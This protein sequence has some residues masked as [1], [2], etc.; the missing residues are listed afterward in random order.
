MMNIDRVISILAIII[1]L[2][3]VYRDE[4]VNKNPILEVKT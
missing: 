3:A 1:A 4:F 2:Y